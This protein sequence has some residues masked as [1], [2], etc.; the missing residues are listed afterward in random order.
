MTVEHVVLFK[1]NAGVEIDEQVFSEAVDAVD[2][3][4]ISFGAQDNRIYAGYKGR[5][6]GF[7]HALVATFE[8]PEA[9]RQYNVH[10]VHL[11]SI[12]NTTVTK[13]SNHDFDQIVFLDSNVFRQETF[14]YHSTLNTCQFNCHQV[15]LCVP[16]SFH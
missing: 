7:T 10:L 15:S 5:T 3:I 11:A 13:P 1:K 6:S 4:K 12:F 16:F 8:S 9:L 2:V 14:Y